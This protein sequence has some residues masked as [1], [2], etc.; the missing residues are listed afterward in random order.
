MRAIPVIIHDLRRCW[1]DLLVFEVLF[2][3]LQIAVLTPPLTWMGMLLIKTTG[4]LAIGNTEIISFFL[5]PLGLLGTF[6]AAAIA[7][8]LLYLEQT[9]IM[10]IAW[11]TISGNRGSAV[12]ALTGSIHRMPILFALAVRQLT[13]VILCLAPLAAIAATTHLMLLSEHDIN[14]YLAHVPPEFTWACVIAATLL[15]LGI[16]I[17][18]FFII[19]WVFAMQEVLFG[20]K[21]PRTALADSVRLVRGSCLRVGG[22]VL[23]CLAITALLPALVTWLLGLL[24]IA[25]FAVAGENLR[26]VIPITAGLLVLHWLA[27]AVVSAVSFSIYVLVITRLYADRSGRRTPARIKTESPRSETA[28]STVSPRPRGWIFFTST[29]ALL[30]LSTGVTYMIADQLDFTHK[31]EVTA[32]RGNSKA[33]PENTLAA[34]RK[35]VESRADFAEIDVQLTADGMVVVI[36]DTDLMRIAGVNRK[37]SEMP[38]D[39]IRAIDAGSWFSPEFKGERIPTL[40]EAIVEARGKI[41]LNIEL[42]SDGEHKTVARRVVEI[43]KEQGFGSQ[44]VITSL[45]YE[46]L[47]EVKRLDP[48]LKTG[49]IAAQ[50]IGKITELDVDFLSVNHAMVDTQ[51]LRAAKRAGKDVHVW[52]VDDSRQMSAMIDRSVKN[53]I[54][55]E[56]DVLVALRNQVSEL[57]DAERL[58]LAF[59]NWMRD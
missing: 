52:T 10:I 54:T 28:A 35:A 32:H 11:E 30:L 26:L 48:Q 13:T 4:R 59:R 58:V 53:I 25:L 16:A 51:L 45:D 29:A 1:R 2:K 46:G 57:G 12:A 22:I 56:V 34:I 20:G 44:C 3:I 39:E 42:K 15:V 36:H 17:L 41:R 19:R 55:D 50:A 7:V 27:M 38:Y 14:Y 18:A 8:T 49:F 24:D 21:T 5:S 9:G 33:A 31:V 37:I 43:V 47:L 40:C 23:A 6:L